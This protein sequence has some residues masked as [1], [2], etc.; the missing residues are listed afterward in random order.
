MLLAVQHEI[1]HSSSISVGTA[2]KSVDQQKSRATHYQD[3]TMD[4]H[5]VHRSCNDCKTAKPLKCK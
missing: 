4:R 2:W 3:L 1:Q 5:K